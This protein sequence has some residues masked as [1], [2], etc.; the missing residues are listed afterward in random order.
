M[1]DYLDSRHGL[2]AGV[3]SW[4]RIQ[5]NAI[6]GRAKICGSYGNSALAG[7]EARRHGFDE[8][9]FLTEEGHVA[10]GATCNIFV[11]RGG[12]LVTPCGSENIPEGITRNCVMELARNEL[13]LD[14]VERPVDRS[15]LHLADEIFFTGTAVEVAPVTR[16]ARWVRRHRSG[17]RRASLPVYGGHP[18]PSGELS[19]LAAA[20]LRSGACGGCRTG[21]C[22]GRGGRRRFV[23]R[24][25]AETRGTALQRQVSDHAC[26]LLG[27]AAL[28]DEKKFFD[29]LGDSQISAQDNHSSHRLAEPD[30]LPGETD[31]RLHVVSQENTIMPG[32]PLQQR[33]IFGSR[34]SRILH[35]KHVHGRVP[36]QQ[37][38]DDLALQILVGR[39]RN[40][41]GCVFRA[42]IRRRIP[43]SGERSLISSITWASR[44]RTVSR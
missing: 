32:G 39:K 26:P 8:A 9:I 4:R 42:R 6:P 25:G 7:D 41:A 23:G 3:V 19:P 35:A 10:E 5:D 12:K 30:K 43:D 37:A 44:S 15:E 2:H 16:I 36:A 22:V 29:R 33:P 17:G 14:V 38:S 28:G 40:H 31:Q 20:G 27:L 34:Q 13:H 21:A 24:V 18:R 11:V 1:R